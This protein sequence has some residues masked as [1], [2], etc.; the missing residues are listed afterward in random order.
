MSTNNLY[1]KKMPI[2]FQSND[3]TNTFILGRK[4]FMNNI[5][6]SHLPKNL[7]KNNSSNDP[8][9]TPKPLTDKSYDLKIQRLRLTSIGNAST[10][11]KDINDSIN[12]GSSDINYINSRLSKVR[13]SGSI[14][15]KKGKGLKGYY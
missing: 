6:N 3:G 4:A 7:P 5:H 10:K 2:K 15:P 13:G 9:K 14:A 11:L 1:S 8:L 12:F